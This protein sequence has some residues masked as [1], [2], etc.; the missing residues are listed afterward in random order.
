MPKRRPK[1]IPSLKGGVF[2][3]DPS[4]SITAVNVDGGVLS[5][6]DVASVIDGVPNPFHLDKFPEG[7]NPG[8]VIP[9][10][11]VYLIFW[12]TAWL[13]TPRPLPYTADIINAVSTILYSPYLSKVDQYDVR[14][15]YGH[16]SQRGKLAGTTIVS[17]PVGP[18]GSQ[19][20]A[21]PPYGLQDS[22]VDRLVGNLIAN[23]TLP[24]PDDEPS[25]LYV[26]ILPKGVSNIGF[27]AGGH[28]SSSVSGNSNQAHIAWLINFDGKLSSVTAVFSHVLVESV[29]DPE[30]TAVTGVPGTCDQS[31]TDA[32]TDDER[33]CEIGDICNTT[34]VINGVVVQSYWSDEDQACVVPTSYPYTDFVVN[35]Y[36]VLDQVTLWLLIHGGDPLSVDAGAPTIREQVTLQ[37][38]KELAST[39]SNTSVRETVQTAIAPSGQRG[40]QG[41][42]SPVGQKKRAVRNRRR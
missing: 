15:H 42:N 28:F 4:A 24:R 12:G 19:S 41:T 1:A 16:P 18:S 2:A 23:R 29:T 9:A 14:L 7:A 10:V 37:L 40:H 5:W 38:I 22:D 34:G 27:L 8:P 6:L 26:V 25:A 36:R 35:K 11:K 39:L 32:Q 30:G 33:W 3:R 17:S 20:H 21:D 13:A 31:P